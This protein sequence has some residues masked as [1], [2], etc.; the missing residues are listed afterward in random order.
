MLRNEHTQDGTHFPI[1]SGNEDCNISIDGGFWGEEKSYRLGYGDSGMYDEN[2]S[3][4][5]VSTCMLFNNIIGLT[6]TNMVFVQTAGFSVQTGNAKNVIFKNIHF[7]NCFADGLHINGNTENLIIQN[8]SGQVGDDIVALNMYD[9]QNSSV[10]WGPL[11]N[12]LVE[13]IDLS[14]NSRYKAFRIQPGIYYYD[15]GSQ[16]D[17]SINN[18]IIKNV[19][20]INTFK[21][22]YQTPM[23]KIGT[24]PEKGDTGSGDNIFFENIDIDLYEPIDPLSEYLNS[25]PIRGAF[26]AF[27]IG[28][29]IGNLSLSNINI[30]LHREIYPLSYFLRIG[31]KSCIIENNIEVF[32]PYVNSQL[33]NLTLKNIIVNNKQIADPSEYI[34]I[35]DFKNINRDGNSTAR[36]IIN[37]ISIIP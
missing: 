28:A 8:I 7:E 12:A 21:L 22:Y 5:G 35:T 3:F 6:L 36:G 31:P 9:W 27:E 33:K 15:N 37:N 16:V 11:K 19:K 30:T 24:T 25:D 2:R 18:V 17:C 20:G 1:E 4:F 26:A 13:N 32:D 34:H 23:Y 29:N 10:N 14:P